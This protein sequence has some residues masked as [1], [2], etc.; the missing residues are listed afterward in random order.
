MAALKEVYNI[1]LET[2]VNQFCRDAEPETEIQIWEFITAGYAAEMFLRPG[3]SEQEKS[4]VFHALLLSS[5]T[6]RVEDIISTTPELKSVQHLDRIVRVYLAV[7][8][9]N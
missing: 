6:P 4:L 5:S 3:A 8:P 7:K 2:V 1:P 9:L